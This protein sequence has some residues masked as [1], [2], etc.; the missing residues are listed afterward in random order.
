M[1]CNENITSA[2]ILEDDADWDLNIKRQMYDF[3]R[4]TNA[5]LQPLKH[6]PSTFLDPT[7]QDSL[8]TIE[9]AAP[10]ILMHEIP[11]LK[12]PSLSPY[13]DNWD[14]LWLGHC[15]T[16][17]P[18]AEKNPAIPRGRALQFHDETVPPSVILNRLGVDKMMGHMYPNQT[19]MV[20][21]ATGTYCTA[22]YAVSNAGARRLLY[23]LGV[24]WLHEAVDLAMNKFC[25]GAKPYRMHRCLT[26]QPPLFSPHRP[27]WDGEIDSDTVKKKKPVMVHTAK[28]STAYIRWSTRLN[29]Q[30]I[31][32]GGTDWVDQYA[33]RP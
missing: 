14:L 19:R 10:E 3:A 2:L 18:S 21:H 6:D 9:D 30:N 28:A 11:A 12:V 15:H 5:L 27:V 7:L 23:E 31:I 1:P 20:H 24:H 16:V 32:E 29:M 13:G 4:A 8:H 33:E 22:G 25:V 26:V 17:V